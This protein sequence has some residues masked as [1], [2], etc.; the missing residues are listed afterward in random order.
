VLVSRAGMA[1]NGGSG[2]WVDGGG[3]GRQ[4]WRSEPG[5]R[6]ARCPVGHVEDI[7]SVCRRRRAR[8]SQRV[9]QEPPNLPHLRVCTWASRRPVRRGARRRRTS[10]AW[11]VTCRSVSVIIDR[12][13]LLFSRPGML[14][15]PKEMLLGIGSTDDGPRDARR[16]SPCLACVT[17]RTAAE[18]TSSLLQ[19]RRGGHSSGPRSEQM[20]H[21]RAG[22]SSSS[23]ASL[24]YIPAIN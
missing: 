16:T 1:A 4:V 21:V 5:T 12:V 15:S 18:T 11:V 24:V 9:A 20:G 23:S 10:Y 17:C 14:A 13:R 8:P 19:A 7:E 22:A 6:S 2:R 3:R